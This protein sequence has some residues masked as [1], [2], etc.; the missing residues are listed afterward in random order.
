MTEKKI[1]LIDVL[2][3]PPFNITE[4]FRDACKKAGI[5]REVI[6]EVDGLKDLRS[7][8]QREEQ[9]AGF[10][11]S[12]SR[13]NLSDGVTEWMS[14]LSSVIRRY[15]GRCPILGVCFGHQI[16]AHVFGGQVERNPVKKEVG[17]RDIILTNAA[18]HDALFKDIDE[19]MRVQMTHGDSVT[20]MP[21]G[22]VLLAYNDYAP[23]QA[24]RLGETWGIQF[25]PELTPQIFEK[26]LGGRIQSLRTDGKHEEA[27]HYQGIL[28]RV[29]DCPEGREVLVRFIKYCLER[30]G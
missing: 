22:A 15:H 12:G 28:E 18:R 30:E 17:S 23:I 4:I 26:L 21:S 9:S 13:H 19:T 11:I 10:V 24:F 3:D 7:T 20:S 5:A 1:T 6:V 8:I 25:H 2:D 27:R 14:E 29:V 16:I